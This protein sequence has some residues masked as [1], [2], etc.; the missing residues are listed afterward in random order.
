MCVLATTRTRATFDGDCADE[1]KGPSLIQ[2]APVF[3]LTGIF[4]LFPRISDTLPSSRPTHLQLISNSSFISQALD[5]KQA[6]KKKAEEDRIA[7]LSAAEQQKVRARPHNTASP[8]PFRPPANL[9][10]S[11][12]SSPLPFPHTHTHRAIRSPRDVR[13][14]SRSRWR[15]DEMSRPTD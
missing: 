1:S 11:T 8:P 13:R 6:A 5:A 3:H 10:L 4:F 12:P 15:T 14:A 2:S 7:K 9:A